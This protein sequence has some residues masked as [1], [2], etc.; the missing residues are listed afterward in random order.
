MS[1]RRKK[2]PALPPDF[3][4][5]TPER[6]AR[7]EVIVENFLLDGARGIRKRH[8][9]DRLAMYLNRGN[10]DRDQ[11]KAG[12][13]F[14]DDAEAAQVSIPSLLD[15]SRV[16]GGDGADARMVR[17][18]LEANMATRRIAQ[19]IQAMGIV[20]SRAVIAVCLA[21][22]PADLWAQM[23]RYRPKDGI[24]ALRMGLQALVI[25][26]GLDNSTRKL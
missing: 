22:T 15:P 20:N 21:N 17:A 25:H 2:S 16:G 3:V 14:I 8:K 12:Q 9:V 13:R 26:Y 1:K 11:H 23:A 6:I 24:G 7:G 4:G 10:I 5:A 19:A 18:G